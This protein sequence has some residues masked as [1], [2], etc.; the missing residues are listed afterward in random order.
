MQVPEANKHIQVSAFD[1]N[2]ARIGGKCIYL[3]AYDLIHDI[4]RRDQ[5]PWEVFKRLIK[6]GTILETVF[7]LDS[8]GTLD[9]E[10]SNQLMLEVLYEPAR[11]AVG[12]QPDILL[13]GHLF[14]LVHTRTP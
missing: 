3:I 13:L 8:T 11:I 4:E 6:C 2:Q 12:Q 10:P 7:D 9:D 14:P 1:L 5:T